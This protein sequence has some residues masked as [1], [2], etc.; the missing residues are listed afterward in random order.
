MLQRTFCSCDKIRF[1][2]HA[3]SNN[4]FTICLLLT[5]QTPDRADRCNYY[6]LVSAAGTK[7]N[8]DCDAGA[9]SHQ[10]VIYY[11]EPSSS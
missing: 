9:W 3:H 1:S 11:C 10:T 4:M 6:G 2:W 5:S 8:K 7:S